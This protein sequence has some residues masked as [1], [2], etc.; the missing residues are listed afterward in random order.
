MS[1]YDVKYET[2]GSDLFIFIKTFDK[3]ITLVKKRR[4]YF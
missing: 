4:K 3:K 2:V 1:T